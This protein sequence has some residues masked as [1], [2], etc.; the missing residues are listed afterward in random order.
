MPDSENVKQ[1]RRL[2][3]GVV[4]LLVLL[5]MQVAI[6]L[7]F[8]LVPRPVDKL[9]AILPV[10]LIVGL[11]VLVPALGITFV[12][13]LIAAQ[14]PQSGDGSIIAGYGVEGNETATQPDR[15]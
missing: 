5:N 6:G 7:Y 2:L 14:R 8:Y 3:T 10:A 15:L 9:L 1:V 11:V 13:W 4:F 12:R